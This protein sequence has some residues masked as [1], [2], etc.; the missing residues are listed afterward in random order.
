MRLIF[1]NRFYW[2]ETPATGQLLTDLAEFMAQQGYKVDVICSHPGGAALPLTEI[3]R[4]VSIHRVRS[5]RSANSSL[6]HKAVDLGTFYVRALLRLLALADRHTIVVNLTDPPLLGI[7]ASIAAGLRGARLIHWIQDIYPEL[8]IELAG[9]HWLR[10][11]QPLRDMAWRTADHCVTLGVEMDANVEA[12]GVPSQRRTVIE[13]WP[14]VGL[15]PM[16]RMDHGPARKALGVTGKFVV[17]YSGNLG[18]VH[19]LEPVLVIAETLR[20]Q[21]DIVF[22]FVGGGPQ[23]DALETEARSRALGNVVFQPAR[24]REDLAD[25]LASAD[26][27]LVTLRP[28]CE[29]LVFPSKLYG[30]AA[31][32]R[33]ILFVGPPGSEV[34]QLIREHEMGFAGSR[35]DIA[36]LA[37]AICRLRDDHDT[38]NACANAAARFAAT[39][40]FAEA[41]SRWHG[42]I[43]ATAGDSLVA[44]FRRTTE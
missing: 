1:V 27:H 43:D 38:W 36:A 13:N 11:I 23:R 4:G 41:S 20:E 39:R 22:V 8:A 37:Q 26:V 40:S 19:D 21:A 9:Q 2:P 35:D 28:G 12:A 44:R 17:G 6:H 10:L 32:G 25:S 34:A 5:T 14:P 29:R 30:S 33:P 15:A 31:V 16:A 7:G 42:V 3:H 24:T 18:R